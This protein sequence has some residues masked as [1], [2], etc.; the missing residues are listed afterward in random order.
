[1]DK[2]RIE[3]SMSELSLNDFLLENGY[4]KFHITENIKRKKIENGNAFSYQKGNSLIMIE[5]EHG[6]WTLK[7]PL[8]T[9]INDD[10]ATLAPVGDRQIPNMMTREDWNE[11]VRDKGI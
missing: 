8:M 7:Y 9:I 6:M 11:W 2:N 3:N 1:M 4:E 10:I 5:K